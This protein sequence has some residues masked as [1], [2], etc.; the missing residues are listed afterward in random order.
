MKKLIASALAVAAL[1][2]A[3]AHAQKRAA[4]TAYKLQSQLSS[5]AWEGKAVTHSQ[6]G[7]MQFAGGQLL[8]RGNQLT[9]GTVTVD[10]KSLK[11]S[12]IPE[13]D[14]L[15]TFVGHVSSDD[16]FGVE[17][18]PTA[19]FRLTKVTPVKGTAAG[20]ATITGDLTI[21][22]KTHPITFP[23]TVS[24]KNGVATAVGTATVDRTKYD[25]RY[26][27]NSFFQGLGDKAIY[28]DFTLR[29]NLVAK[30]NGV[31]VR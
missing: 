3:P 1:F 29:F 15:A 26:G 5:L 8:V 22:D 11:V 4:G 25:V 23:A 24:V 10:M 17:K 31:A 21:K 7:T 18:Y 20:N 14:K 12:S 13:A 19:T 30:Q 16:F 2:A 9:G 27:S 28:D 6:Q